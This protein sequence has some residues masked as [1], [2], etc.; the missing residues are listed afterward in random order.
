MPAPD[1]HAEARR[2]LIHRGDESLVYLFRYERFAPEPFVPLCPERVHLL[3]GAKPLYRPPVAASLVVLAEPFGHGHVGRLLHLDIQ[4]GIYFE[5]A[6]VKE[7]L[8]V[9]LFHVPAHML[10]KVRADPEAVGGLG[11][12]PYP[13]VY[14]RV[15]LFGRNVPL[16]DHPAEYELLPRL[17]KVEVGPGRVLARRLGQAREHGRL[18]KVELF[19]ILAEVRLGRGLHAVGAVAEVYLVQVEAQYLVLVELPFD[20]VG[21]YRLA[22]L[23]RKLPFVGQKALGELLRDGGAALDD[24]AGA[25]VLYERPE[26]GYVA[27]ALVLVELRVLGRE[28]GLYQ[29]RGHLV[30]GYHYPALYIELANQPPVV[31]IDIRHQVG[32]VALKVGERREAAREVVVSSGERNNNN[33]RKRKEVF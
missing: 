20:A 8:T 21:H 25:D 5:P 16:L 2:L 27:D 32:V 26:D 12:E 22:H 19:D 33:E 13:C 18:G 11:L 6:L 4:G 15:R 10:R 17:G 31:R 7:V 9:L 14:R 24:L 29:V 23:A 30:K 3:Y 28:E 1:V